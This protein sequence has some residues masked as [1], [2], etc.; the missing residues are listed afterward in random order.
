MLQSL[1]LIHATVPA[2]TS[3]SPTSVCQV[4]RQYDEYDVDD[5]EGHSD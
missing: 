5:N 3:K 2:N 4:R 1:T